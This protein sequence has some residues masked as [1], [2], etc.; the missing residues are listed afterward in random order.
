MESILS[1]LNGKTVDFLNY[2]NENPFLWVI[3]GILVVLLIIA[4]I[5]KMPK[6]LIVIAVISVV[7]VGFIFF[8]GEIPTKEI[9]ANKEAW[10]EHGK[11]LIEKGKDVGKD[12]IEKG[13]EEL[14]KKTDG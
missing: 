5:K 14:K 8:A 12:L 7:Y 13:K 9:P 6:L 3:L 1:Y 10:I 2:L 4:I 11:E